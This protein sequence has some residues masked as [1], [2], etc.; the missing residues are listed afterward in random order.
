MEKDN[1]SPNLSA[2]IFTVLKNRITHWEYLPDHRLTEIGLS[3]EFGVSRSPIREVLQ[4]L[5][6]KGLVIKVPRLGYTVRQL[7]M[8]EIYELYEYRLA[9]ESYIIERL[10]ETGADNQL[11]RDLHQLWQTFITK[12]PEIDEE[13]A[14]QDEHFHETLAKALGNSVLYQRVIEVDERLHFIRVNDITTPERWIL[15]CKQH[16]LILDMIKQKDVEGARKSIKT[17]IQEGRENV[18]QAI[19]EALSRAYLKARARS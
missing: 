18:D 14:L 15:T 3:E 11:L 5:E 17:N 12:M 4:M 10:A 2:E 16:L 7:N 8:D 19:K 6:E 9:V 13:A 1:V